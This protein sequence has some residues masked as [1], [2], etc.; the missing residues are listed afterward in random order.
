MI[1]FLV[2][3]ALVFGFFFA[4]FLFMEILLGHWPIISGGIWLA[5]TLLLIYAASF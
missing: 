2:F 3:I 5:S 4:L 1:A